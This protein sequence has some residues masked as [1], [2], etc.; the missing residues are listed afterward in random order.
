M[1]AVDKRPETGDTIS[2]PELPA[3][4]PSDPQIV[5]WDNISYLLR[6]NTANPAAMGWRQVTVDFPSEFKAFS[7]QQLGL[8]LGYR[9]T[10]PLL[11]DDE[12]HNSSGVYLTV[13][14]ERATMPAVIVNRDSNSR[15]L[16][17]PGRS[18]NILLNETTD[19]S[20]LLPGTDGKTS[21]KIGTRMD[22]HQFV[23]TLK[24]DYATFKIRA[25]YED[26]QD[27]VSGGRIL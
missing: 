16:L 2:L 5:I 25:S 13:S 1:Y 4:F 26:Y 8:T 17:L 21:E 22:F 19:F 24:G 10:P 7:T 12:M 23:S 27:W 14:G 15:L 11:S 20:I 6:R 3:E 9:E 18:K